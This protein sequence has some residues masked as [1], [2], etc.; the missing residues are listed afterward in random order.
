MT[1]KQYS[2]EKVTV[3]T[4]KKSI[5]AMASRWLRRK[6]SQRLDGSGSLEA[7]F[8]QRE[9]V[10]SETSKPSMRSSPWMRGA[11]QLGFSAIIWKMR[12][13]TSFGA[14]LLPMGFL[15]FE[16]I[17]QYQLNPARC[18]RTTVSGVTTRSACFQ[19]DQDR[20]TSSQKSLSDKSSFG[21]GL[22]LLSTT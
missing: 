8:I 22:R 2:T 19:P 7:R 17:L 16:I 4:V 13:R 9:M 14:C 5:A 12:S 3:G 20:R 6:V 21:R 1:K 10:L 11:P 18:Q 15:V